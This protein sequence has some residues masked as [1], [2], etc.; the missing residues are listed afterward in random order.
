M[1]NIDAEE[2]QKVRKMES[3]SRSCESI[4]QTSKDG[5]SLLMR[6]VT[7]EI[8]VLNYHQNDNKIGESL[9]VL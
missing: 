1:N 9:F 2:L 8:K 6:N 3:C 7:N 4:H 5:A